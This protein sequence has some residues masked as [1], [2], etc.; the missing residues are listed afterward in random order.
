MGNVDV[1]QLFNVIEQ[2]SLEREIDRVRHEL[3]LSERKLVELEHRVINII[4]IF[5]VWLIYK[6]SEFHLV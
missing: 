2:R 6:L 5:F 4:I 3:E 1:T